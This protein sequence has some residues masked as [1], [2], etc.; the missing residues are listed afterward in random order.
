MTS[1]DSDLSHTRTR[2]KRGGTY[3]HI[4]LQTLPHFGGVFFL[5]RTKIIFRLEREQSERKKKK[6]KKAKA[7]LSKAEFLWRENYAVK[8]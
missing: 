3:N 5:F 1:L 8:Q 4:L 2:E 6:R 7:I